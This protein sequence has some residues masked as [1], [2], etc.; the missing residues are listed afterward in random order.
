[1]QE[2]DENA[3]ENKSEYESCYFEALGEGN[4]KKLSKK[5]SAIEILKIL[6]EKFEP[7][8][9]ISSKKVNRVEL[10]KSNDKYRSGDSNSENT[11]SNRFRKSKAK[12]IVK[13]KKTSPDYG[14]G[15]INPIS[16]LIQIQ[17]AKKEP[18]PEFTFIVQNKKKT[19]QNNRNKR[20]EFVIQ[21]TLTTN[22]NNVGKDENGNN[23][24]ED[25]TASDSNSKLVKLQ[26]EGKG[27]TKK[28]AKKNA[29]EAML[30]KLGYQS[31]AS[32]LKPSIKTT[33]QNTSNTITPSAST[34][35]DINV[36]AEPPNADKAA[37]N[38]NEKNEKR[39]TFVE[40]NNVTIQPDD[41]K[42]S[43]I[44]GKFK[45]LIS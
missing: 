25:K 19:E 28:E 33:T 32:V 44:T 40:D 26:C 45:I 13:I 6:K 10:A 35:G 24:I 30:I 7:L 11:A 36:I 38:S 29:A 18:E 5:N 17:Q 34:T 31:K 27:S 4:S 43:S 16:R 8:F 37:N 20:T 3:E 22:S 9:M 42:S 23:T 21:V 41:Y 12:N 39:V 14:K 2:K 15:S 1:M